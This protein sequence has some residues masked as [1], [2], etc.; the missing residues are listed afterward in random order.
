MISLI[1]L[2][3]RNNTDRNGEIRELMCGSEVGVSEKM[4]GFLT[5]GL[6]SQHPV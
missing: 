4:L 2:V 3:T 5:V 1:L 6:F